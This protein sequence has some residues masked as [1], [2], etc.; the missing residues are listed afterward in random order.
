[1][2]QASWI[3]FL[4][5]TVGLL[6]YEASLNDQQVTAAGSTPLSGAPDEGSWPSPWPTTDEGAW[7][8]PRK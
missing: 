1:M 6:T 5:L 3:A 8:E 2:R 4:L 7:P